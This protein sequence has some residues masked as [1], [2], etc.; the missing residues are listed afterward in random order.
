MSL[1]HQET[2]TPIP[3]FEAQSC[4]QGD[5]TRVPFLGDILSRCTQIHL[6]GVGFHPQKSLHPPPE[7]SP[8]G[9]TSHSNGKTMFQLSKI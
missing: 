4:V 8:F 3:V 5:L 7:E 6:D 1:K 9:N 2:T